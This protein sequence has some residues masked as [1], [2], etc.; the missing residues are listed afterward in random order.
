MNILIFSTLQTAST[1]AL[2]FKTLATE[3]TN[4]QRALAGL[5]TFSLGLGVAQLAGLVKKPTA[6]PLDGKFAPAQAALMTATA[7]LNIAKIVRSDVNVKPAKNAV[8]AVSIGIVAY[9]AYIDIKSGQA[10]ERQRE[11]ARDSFKVTTAPSN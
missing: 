6:K 4:K 5:G 7:A 10:A 11:A 8:A 9:K 1:T 2:A 3:D